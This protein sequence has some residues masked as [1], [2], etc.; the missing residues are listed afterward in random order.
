MGCQKLPSYPCF[1]GH[2]RQETCD[3]V[4]LSKS[5]R[6]NAVPNLVDRSVG[7]PQ[8]V[9]HF[10]LLFS[11][12]GEVFPFGSCDISMATKISCGKGFRHSKASRAP[13]AKPIPERWFVRKNKNS[14]D[15]SSLRR[16][17]GIGFLEWR[18]NASNICLVKSRIDA[19]KSW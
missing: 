16:N 6:G 14:R 12:I 2:G 7:I 1:I 3:L 19:S 10:P 8:K 17:T 13:K 15:E 9:N 18:N 11:W 4:K 5:Y